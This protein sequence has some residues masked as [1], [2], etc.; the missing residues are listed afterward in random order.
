V[1]KS[2]TS[3]WKNR[4]EN[5]NK[6]KAAGK[7]ENVRDSLPLSHDKFEKQTKIN[8]NSKHTRT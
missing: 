3:W 6:E 7:M 1:L 8:I 5:N 4:G 2:H